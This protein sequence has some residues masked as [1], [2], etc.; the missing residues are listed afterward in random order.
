MSAPTSLAPVT[1]RAASSSVGQSRMAGRY[2]L[3][4]SSS[5]RQKSV[6]CASLPLAT[7]SSGAIPSLRKDQRSLMQARSCRVHAPRPQEL[8]ELDALAQPPLHHLGAADHLS[9]N[10]AD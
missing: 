4:V 6:L 7:G 3:K 1:F 10:V 5:V 8:E 2:G 9:H